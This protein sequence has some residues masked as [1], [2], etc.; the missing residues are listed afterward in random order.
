MPKDQGDTTCSNEPPD[1]S[2]HLLSPDHLCFSYFIHGPFLSLLHAGYFLPHRPL[3]SLWNVLVRDIIK[4]CLMYCFQSLS[5]LLTTASILKSILLHVTWKTFCNLSPIFF[6]NLTC[7][8]V[9]LVPRVLMKSAPTG[10]L[11]ILASELSIH[12]IFFSFLFLL[13]RHWCSHLCSHEELLICLLK[14]LSLSVPGISYLC[15]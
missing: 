8:L 3:Y 9:P 6:P 11:C 5:S 14:C 1:P 10:S 7:A 15:L 12:A 4:F 2:P 13:L